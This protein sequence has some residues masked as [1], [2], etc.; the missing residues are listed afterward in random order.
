M[1]EQNADT[2]NVISMQREVLWIDFQS[3]QPA[4]ELR[5]ALASLCKVFRSRPDVQ[6]FYGKGAPSLIIIEADNPDEALLKQFLTLKQRFPRTPIILLVRNITL[7]LALWA[8]KVRVWDLVHTPLDEHRRQELLERLNALL[9]Q[10]R[11]PNEARKAIVSSDT[12]TLPSL[13]QLDKRGLTRLQPALAIIRTGF[14]LHVSESEL[15]QSCAMSVHH[16]SRTFSKLMGSPLQ[17]YIVRIRLEAAANMLLT[18]SQPISTIALDVGFNDASY[19]SRAFR[20]YYQ[21]SPTEFRAN[22]GRIDQGGH[23]KLISSNP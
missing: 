5:E 13:Q 21:I 4:H 8:I 7:E 14:N 6:L 19:F 23:P 3:Q 2:R 18:S 1:I 12:V 9:N 16:F 11:R 15:A 22:H 17:E 10:L 20:K